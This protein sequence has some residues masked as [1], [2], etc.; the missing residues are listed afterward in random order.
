MCIYFTNAQVPE[1]AP[2]PPKSRRLLRDAA[3]K[4][5]SADKPLLGLLP[6]LLCFV[7]STLAFN[8]SHKIPTSLGDWGNGFTGLILMFLP[9]GYVL[10]MGVLGSFIGIQFLLHRSRAYL[11]RMIS[12]GEHEKHLAGGS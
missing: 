11:R 1:L 4:Q 6:V 9:L 10:L 12:S 2:F 7:S 5:M 8:T 3:F